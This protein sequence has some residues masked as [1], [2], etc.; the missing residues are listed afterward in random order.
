MANPI[1]AA[2]FKQVATDLVWSMGTQ[3]LAEYGPYCR[4]DS[5]RRAS[6]AHAW[7]FT[8][9]NIFQ[10]AGH[11]VSEGVTNALP[12]ANGKLVPAG[13]V[14]GECARLLVANAVPAAASFNHLSFVLK[15]DGSNREY[16]AMAG[17]TSATFRF[18]TRQI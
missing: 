8:S 4:F 13:G 14:F 3:R 18:Q 2:I 9:R 7:I 11:G 15:M 17:R 1:F 6:G 5:S 12:V 10:K 16:F